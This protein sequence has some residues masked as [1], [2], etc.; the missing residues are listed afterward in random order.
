M[1]DVQSPKAIPNLPKSIN[2]KHRKSEEDFG[3]EK[4]AAIWGSDK[5]RRINGLLTINQV[6]N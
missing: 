1:E 4:A 5:N 6:N 2:S 3:Y